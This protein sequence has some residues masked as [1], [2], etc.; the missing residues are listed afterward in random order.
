MK[1][2]YNPLRKSTII[3]TIFAGLEVIALIGILIHSFLG[4]EESIWGYWGSVAVI[5]LFSPIYIYAIPNAIFTVRN[6]MIVTRNLHTP[7]SIKKYYK[8]SKI[9][10]IWGVITG[11][12]YGCLLAPIFLL[13]NI[14]LYSAYKE[15]TERTENT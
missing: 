4:A 13:E 14:F 8:L 9:Y 12:L 7:D 2:K 6:L 1:M 5:A 10:L 15:E 11:G 3:K